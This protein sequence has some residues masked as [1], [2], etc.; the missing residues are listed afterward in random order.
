MRKELPQQLLRELLKNSKR[1]DRELS[2]ILGVSQPTI[3]RARTKLV[4]EGVIKE[5]ELFCKGIAN[6]K[7]W[8]DYFGSLSEIQTA[9]SLSKDGTLIKL[10]VTN[11][12]ELA[13][14][15]PK[16][17]KINKGWFKKKEAPIQ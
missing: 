17:G 3:T 4:N 15:T 5:L 11:K 1:S 6:Q 2:K 9:S 13:D 12:K 8:A 14:M 16:Q 7:E 10:S